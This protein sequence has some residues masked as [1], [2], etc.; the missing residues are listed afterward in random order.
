MADELRTSGVESDA[1][2]ASAT[3]LASTFD[4]SSGNFF[5]DENGDEAEEEEDDDDDQLGR[6]QSLQERQEG[7][8]G[9]GD[10]DL[11][12]VAKSMLSF[13]FLTFFSLQPSRAS[14]RIEWNRK[15]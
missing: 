6:K 8:E 12:R 5:L 3:N 1:E 11:V 7:K 2:A 9:R 14:C 15:S 10:I 4:P 13:F